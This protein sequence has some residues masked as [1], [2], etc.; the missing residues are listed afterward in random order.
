[1]QVDRR[2]VQA[3]LRGFFAAWGLPATVRVDNGQPWGSGDDLPP[4]L[5]LWLVGLGIAMHWNRP[6]HSQDNAVIERAHG[7]CQRWVEPGTCP[8]GSELQTRLDWATR[9]Q[10]EGYPAVAGHSRLVAYP[11]LRDGGRPYDPVQEATA[12]QV[13]RVWTFLARQHW[14]RRVDKVGH[15]SLYNRAVPVGRPWAGTTV[16]VQFAV[17]DGLPTWII[18]TDDGRCIATPPAPEL[19]RERIMALDVSHRRLRAPSGGK[20]H[21]RSRG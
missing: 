16:T 4:D 1:M 2:M 20:P 13:Q 17:R 6:R 19:G 15:I 18:R 11:A 12:W 3:A 21:V 10:R 7:V 8:D 9:W 14:R 5:A